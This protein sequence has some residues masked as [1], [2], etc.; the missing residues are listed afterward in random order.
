VIIFKKLTFAN[1]LSVGNQPITIELDKS[2]TTLVHGTNGSGKSTILDALTYSLFNKPFRKVNLPQLVN[3]QNKKG[4]LTEIEFSIGNN[5]FLVQRGMKPKV[6]RVFKNGEEIDAKAADKDNQSHLEQNILKLT[7]KSFT[8]VVILGSSNFVPFMQLNTAGRR[9]CVE[10]FL[11]I[12]VFSL[13]GLIAKERLRG[14]KDHIHTLE[15]DISNLEY[16]KD[17]Q[18]DRIREL[19]EQS[20]TAVEELE[21]KIENLQTNIDK[22]Q[23]SIEQLQEMEQEVIEEI[24][25]LQSKSPASRVEEFKRVITMMRVKI[26]TADKRLAFFRDN[27]VC[28]HCN[29]NIE[30]GVKKEQISAAQDEGDEM[31][32]GINEA[33]TH[34]NT[35]ERDIT[36]CDVLQG[37]VSKLQ[38]EIFRRQ[39]I[40]DTYQN[41][42]T[43][44]QKSLQTTQNNTSILDKEEGKMEVL[45]E[46]LKSLLI[47]KG[48]LVTTLFEHDLV[49]GLLKDS[50]IKTQVVKKYLPVM[51]K[52][53]RKY[54]TELDLP[55]HFILDEEFNETVSSPLH[56]DF[57]YASFSE[58]Q[59]SR[60]D[61]A[62]MFTWREVGRL[63]NSVSTN[64]LILDEVFSS[65]LDEVGKDNLL[66]LLRYKLDDNQRIVVV[67]HTLSQEFKEKFDR[68]VEV[69]RI[70][71]FSRYS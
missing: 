40:V 63:K 60:I 11:D 32:S 36:S 59:K 12:K 41:T 14:L 5:D 65:S 44:A 33:T 69:S 15:G 23:K 18:F 8:Q 13:M 1:F 58:G 19:R 56:Q 57:S 29:Q 52:C 54:L 7:Y 61:L 9:E 48:D 30:E 51:N 45:E 66:A 3:T 42:L 68:T 21:G 39:T 22:E 10:D 34:L 46:D 31:R 28:H 64:L 67:D 55:I 50:G 62:L 4:L 25:K 71:G 20:Q 53:I 38:N 70:G 47:R 17:L 35:L 2:K 26:D 24:H 16:K 43:D 37:K 27:D 6:F 49:V